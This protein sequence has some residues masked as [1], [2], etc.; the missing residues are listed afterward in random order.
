M[1]T[2]LCLAFSMS[3]GAV[4]YTYYVDEKA[5]EM[6]DA[7]VVEKS[8]FSESSGEFTLVAP[9]DIAADSDG[10]LYVCDSGA[11]KILVFDS[12]L[13][14]KNEIANF[15]LPDGQS[16]VLKAPQGISIDKNNNICIAD[17]ES[18]RVLVGDLQGNIS[19]VITVTD[20][21]LCICTGVRSV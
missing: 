20:K 9:S 5:V 21:Q 17:S 16:T 3:A 18:G 10:N 11:G 12:E 6:P 2:A 7:A 4:S 13:K 19:R 1:F 15:T 14:F 8:I